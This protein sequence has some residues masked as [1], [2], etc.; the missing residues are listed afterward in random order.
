MHYLGFR[1]KEHR[2]VVVIGDMNASAIADDI[3]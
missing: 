3:N 1:M 2:W